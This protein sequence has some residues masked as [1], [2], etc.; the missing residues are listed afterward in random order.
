MLLGR[1]IQGSD[2]EDL[3]CGMSWRVGPVH[4]YAPGWVY[5]RGEWGRG[6]GG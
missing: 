3:R 5:R 6:E 4:D 1:L 2:V